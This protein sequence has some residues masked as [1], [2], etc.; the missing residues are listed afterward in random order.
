M[1]RPW[2]WGA[3]CPTRSGVRGGLPCGCTN[4]IGATVAENRVHVHEF[5][6]TILHPLG[7]DHERLTYQYGGRDYRLT[8]VHG[9]VVTALLAWADPFTA[10]PEDVGVRPVRT[11]AR[12]PH[13]SWVPLLQDTFQGD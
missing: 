12:D 9:D 13:P 10:D 11:G 1:A 6:A 4:D 2:G 7:M 3:G 5:H 8:D